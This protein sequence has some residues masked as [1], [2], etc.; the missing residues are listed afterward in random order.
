MLIGAECAMSMADMKSMSSVGVSL[1]MSIG[2]F[3]YDI[4]K[5]VDLDRRSD[6]GIKGCEERRPRFR[7]RVFR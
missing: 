5:T 6:C 7:R 4:A 1:W 3:C 2:V